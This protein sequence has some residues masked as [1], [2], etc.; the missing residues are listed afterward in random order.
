MLAIEYGCDVVGVDIEPRPA[1][2]HIDIKNLRYIDADISVSH[3][4]FER[5]SFDRIISL[6]V[7]EHVKH[8]YCNVKSVFGFAGR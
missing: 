2:D 3:D 8:P 1:W 6:V 4:L 7:W 5:S